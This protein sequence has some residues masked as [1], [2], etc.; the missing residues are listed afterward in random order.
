MAITAGVIRR[1]NLYVDQQEQRWR[2]GA[3]TGGAGPCNRM[4]KQKN[5]FGRN[6][7]RIT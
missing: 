1:M 4:T 5:G 6:R 3:P 7:D 2:R